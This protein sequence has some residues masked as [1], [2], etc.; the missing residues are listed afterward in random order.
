MQNRATLDLSLYLVTDR[1]LCK[2]DFLETINQAVKGGVT[3]VQLREKDCSTRDFIEL[4]KQVKEILKPYNVPLIINDRID[5]AMAIDAE[6]VHLG[7]SDMPHLIARE[8]LGSHKIIGISVE[9]LEEAKECNK[10]DAD[11]IAISPIFS[12]PTKGDTAPEFGLQGAKDVV[13]ITEHKVVAIGGIN[14]SN[15][16]DVMQTGIDGVA[17]V[18]AIVSSDNPQEAS[19]ELA[20]LIKSSRK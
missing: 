16:K 8:L 1:G 18:S 2:G 15:L 9:N 11:Y 12:T 13:E 3:I 20:S 5:V 10:I 7:Q 19:N 17:V 14:T 6:G 4:A